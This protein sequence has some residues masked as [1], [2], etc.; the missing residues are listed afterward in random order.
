[1]KLLTTKLALALLILLNPVVFAAKVPV[2]RVLDS[3]TVEQQ[4]DYVLKRSTTY[5]DYKVVKVVWLN[6]LRKNLLDSLDAGKNGIKKRDILLITREEEVDSLINNLEATNATLIQ[7]TKERDS[8]SLFG[9]LVNKSSYN[10]ILFTIII[11]LA[12]LLVFV[13]YMFQR[14]N[15]TTNA[16][17]KEL[18]DLKEDFE[19]HRKKSREREEKMAR[20]HLDEV[21][22]YKNRT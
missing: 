9:Y 17:K 7:T 22:K 8:M 6:K 20:R 10:S 15:S 2:E 16:T 1:M 12:T 19:N 14:S 11:L 21:L 18:N 3:A 5:E 13:F 4:I